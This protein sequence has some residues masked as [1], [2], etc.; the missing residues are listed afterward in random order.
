MSI[1]TVNDLGARDQYVASAAQTVFPYTYPIFEDADLVVDV[2]GVTKALATD[3]TVS[4][5]TDDTGGN[6]T[7]LTPMTG[8]EIVTIYRDIAIERVTDMSQNG[9]WTSAS[10]NDEFD[11]LTL[12]DQQ[13]E[14]RIGR[15]LRLPM[16][17]SADAEDMELSPL[18]NWLGKFL[19]INSMG[20]PEPATFSGSGAALSQS[21][22]AAL[23]N[24]QTDAESDA[25]I[26]P[27]NYQY[28]EGD[29]RRYGAVGDGSTN[30]TIACEA[31]IS[32]AVFSGFVRFLPELA[33]GTTVYLTDELSVPSGVTVEFGPNTWV[34]KRSGT[35]TNSFVF[36][37]DD[38]TLGTAT[39]L[40]SDGTLTAKTVDVDSASGLSVGMTVL[41]RD[42]VYAYS[43]TGRNQEINEIEGISGTTIT[44]KNRLMGDYTTSQNAQ[45]IP[46]TTANRD[47]TFINARG[48]IPTGG[49]VGGGVFYSSHGYNHRYVDCESVGSYHNPGV[50]LSACTNCDIDRGYYRDGQDF[51]TA[52]RGYAVSIGQGSKNCHARKVRSKNVRESSLSSGAA[53][54]TFDNC[55]DEGAY[56]SSWNTHAN[57]VYQCGILNCISISAQSKAIV[58]GFTGGFAPDH[59][60]V[61]RGN[62]ILNPGGTGI[63]TYSSVGFEQYDNVIEDNEI[64]GF[65]RAFGSK[66]GI[67]ASRVTRTKFLRNKIL[68]GTTTNAVAGVYAEVLVDGELI[69]NEIDGVPSGYGIRHTGCTGLLIQENNIRNIS[70]ATPGVYGP[71]TA[72]TGVKVLRNTVDNDTAFTKNS[73]DIHRGNVYATKFDENYGTANIADGGTITHLCIRTPTFANVQPS[74]SGELA[75]VTTIGASTITVAL[76]THANGAGTTQDVYWEI[77]G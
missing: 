42:D 46:F 38:Y 68:K 58:V 15:A 33:A 27:T 41:L 55:V 24:P 20:L 4:G 23:L 65:G 19:Y 62:L 44:L 2:D 29:V 60:N 36:R 73:G 50:L 76:K 70:A 40:S 52:G 66:Y 35:G 3:Y 59:H 6:V 75:G 21:V 43:T 71:A 22:L 5:E 11:R 54:C 31:A 37:C 28:L 56:D 16:T 51:T 48:R 77:K 47:I 26:T 7:F 67:Y 72:S 49:S 18:S 69:G 74:V 61:I 25:G 14:E 34:E 30:S 13:L 32:V 12:I 57:G 63:E 45:L 39:D 8:G 9:P 1:D 53:Y 17:A 64:I 10:V